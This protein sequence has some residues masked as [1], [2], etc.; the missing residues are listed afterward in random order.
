M[1]EVLEYETE[2]DAWTTDQ[3]VHHRSCHSLTSHTLTLIPLL[4]LFQP[5]MSFCQTLSLVARHGHCT[6]T[7]QHS[8]LS[9]VTSSNG[10]SVF[11]PFPSND[12]RKIGSSGIP[13]SSHLYIWQYLLEKSFWSNVFFKNI[14]IMIKCFMWGTCGSNMESCSGFLRDNDGCLFLKQSHQPFVTFMPFW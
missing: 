10:M 2:N 8:N 14:K 4:Q 1:D 12:F 3:T 5:L 11:L 7:R 13:I 6:T 9:F